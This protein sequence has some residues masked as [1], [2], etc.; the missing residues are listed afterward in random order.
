MSTPKAN[1]PA[2][3]RQV[4]EEKGFIKRPTVPSLPAPNVA[5][6]M[7]KAALKGFEVTLTGVGEEDD[8]RK[9]RLVT[10]AT[11]TG[12]GGE[13]WEGEDEHPGCALAKALAKALRATEPRQGRLLG[14]EAA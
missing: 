6:L 4:L 14:A 1:L 12:S 7:T 9:P 11:V 8:R 2:D 5:E 10:T 13:F 3:V